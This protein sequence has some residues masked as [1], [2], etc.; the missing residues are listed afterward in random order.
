MTKIAD[1]FVKIF[2]DCQK[3]NI[4][5]NYKTRLYLFILGF[6]GNFSIDFA[7]PFKEPP[8]AKKYLLI[9]VEQLTSWPFKFATKEDD[10]EL[11]PKFVRKQI[12]DPLGLLKRNFS[13]NS[14]FF[15]ATKIS[16]LFKRARY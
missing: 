10:A 2:F 4:I 5:N 3:F 6:F 8:F 7:V 11:I 13:D 16:A 15:V 1:K 9:G 12:I 14:I